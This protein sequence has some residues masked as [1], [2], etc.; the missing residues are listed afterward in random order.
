MFDEAYLSYPGSNYPRSPDHPWGDRGHSFAESGGGVVVSDLR[1]VGWW[2]RKE[3]GRTTTVS[4]GLS[5]SWAAGSAPRSRSR[6][7]RSRPSPAGPWT[8]C[9]SEPD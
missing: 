3:S 1:D 9:S 4:V 7:R 2:K 6:P 8:W 5:P